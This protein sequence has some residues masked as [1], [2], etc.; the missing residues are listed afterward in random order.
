MNN[1]FETQRKKI[2]MEDK[3]KTKREIWD[4]VKNYNL[5]VVPV[6]GKLERMRQIIFE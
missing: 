5:H 6:P 2:R 4:T 3:E 1:F